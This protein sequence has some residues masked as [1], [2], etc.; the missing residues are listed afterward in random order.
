MFAVMLVPFIQR[1][2]ALILL[3]MITS[4]GRDL[5]PTLLVLGIGLCIS[6]LASASHYMTTKF[7][8]TGEKLEF[9]TGWIWTK[10]KVVPL[11]RIQSVHIE[12][13]LVHRLF[14]V[15]AVRVDTG[16]TNK[17]EEVQITAIGYE[18]AQRLRQRLL[19]RVQIP[20]ASG[21]SFEAPIAGPDLFRLSVGELAMHGFAH[22]RWFIV[23]GF[24]FG[25]AEYAG[26]EENLFRVMLRFYQ[27]GAAD[28]IIR[29]AFSIVGILMLG[30]L[31]SIGFSLTQFYGFTIHRHPKGISIDR[32]LFTRRQTVVPLNRVSGVEIHANFIMRWLGMSSVSV[33]ILGSKQEEEGGGKMMVSPW[34]QT[35]RLEEMLKMVMPQ[36]T[37]RPGGWR[38]VPSRSIGR[39]LVASLIGYVI[40]GVI[41]FWAFTALS[42][43]GAFSTWRNS[44]SAAYLWPT[45]WAVA[46]GLVSLSV[47]NAIFLVM[48]SRARVTETTVEQQS[49]WLNRKWHIVPISR[50]QMAELDSSRLQRLFNLR[51][52]QIMAPATTLR[53][54]DLEP[55]DAEA[56]FDTARIIRRSI[57]SRGV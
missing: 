4:R 32:G 51:S 28:Q 22:N 27:V 47:A 2:G 49:G 34:V 17:A 19:Q 36:A 39:H 12:Q 8:I 54:V 6:L 25:L 31:V 35:S 45:V 18:E 1:F 40:L 44:P 21:V 20:T 5:T 38:R 29:I 52:V 57:K 37:T 13:N 43:A 46:L 55:A 15:A 14:G 16:V 26:G 42:N 3:L 56:I 24:I 9:H 7:G 50:L 23:V 33:Q 30:W 48:T 10:H 53:S 41:L 11:E